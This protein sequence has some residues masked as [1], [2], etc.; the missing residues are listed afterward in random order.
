MQIAGEDPDWG[1]S[2]AILQDPGFAG[3]MAKHLLWRLE[4]AGPL[5]VVTERRALVGPLSA[6]VGSPEV[7]G[8][9]DRWWPALRAHGAG[10][11]RILT[12]R[13]APAL[14][15]WRVSQ[16]DEYSFVS[17]LTLDESTLWKGFEK[18]CRRNIRAAEKAGITVRAGSPDRDFD[19]AWELFR[20]TSDDGRAFELPARAF[21]RAALGLPAGRL[22]VAEHEGRMVGATLGLAHGHYEGW[23]AGFDR[24]TRPRPSAF[25]YWDIMRRSRAEGLRY[26]DFGPQSLSASPTLTLFKR[27]FSPILRPFYVYEVRRGLRGALVSLRESSAVRRLTHRLDGG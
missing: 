4:Q 19:A 21:L 11:L 23:I 13:R 6:I 27:S 15:R 12:N 2:W 26:F 16:D 25:L 9:F 24:A 18:R 14:E 8:S 22:Y 10:S 17:D 5:Q 3:L 1:G 7:H 20:A